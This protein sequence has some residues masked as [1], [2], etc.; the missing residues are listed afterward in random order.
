MT[1]LKLTR[2]ALTALGILAAPLTAEAQQPANVARVGVLWPGGAAT[3]A[4]RMEAFRQGLRDHG[5]VEG[6]N[7]AF[8]LRYAD[9]RTERLPKLA[10]ELGSLDLDLITPLGGQATRAIQQATTKIPIVA[11]S[12]DFVGEKLVASL[13]RPGANITGISILSSELNV[14]RLE[15][16]KE[17][18]PQVSAVAVL[19]DPATG[20]SQLTTIKVAARS[21]GVRLHI[22]EVRGPDDLAD[23]FRI[24]KE[25][26]AEAV[27]VLASPLLASLQKTIIGLAASNRIPA[28]Y[29]WS[30][31]AKAGGLLSYG[32]DLLAMWRQTGVLV[33]RVLRG[34]NP[35]N[36]PV[37]QPRK[38]EL[39]VNIKAAEALGIIFPPS[40]LLR[41]DKVVE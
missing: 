7:L 41:A 26:R 31:H 24:A 27:N 29:Q 40:I 25:K 4:V 23:V 13:A 2:I 15:L 20:A 28:I 10:A 39:V 22:F 6:R 11:L 16:L 14:K 36:L 37:E 35:S 8:E 19:W 18:L 38:I 30:V 32:P 12:D 9:G 3:L 21:L 33:G 5:Y 1:C 34:A 17:I